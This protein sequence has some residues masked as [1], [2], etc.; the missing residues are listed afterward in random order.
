[1]IIDCHGHYTTEPH[2][3]H[4]FRKKQTEAAKKHEHFPPYDLKV[5]DDQ[6]RESPEE[7]LEC[8][9]QFAT[10]KKLLTVAELGAS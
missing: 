6:I 8:V 2:Q 4:D 10:I 9:R 5:T 1:M 7:I 3:L